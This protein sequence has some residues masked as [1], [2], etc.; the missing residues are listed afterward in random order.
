MILHTLHTHLLK[1]KT[2]NVLHIEELPTKAIFYSSS[3]KRFNMISSR[4]MRQVG[5]LA[6]IVEGGDAYKIVDGKL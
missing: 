2:P 3:L 1:F 5:H 6:Q 4:N